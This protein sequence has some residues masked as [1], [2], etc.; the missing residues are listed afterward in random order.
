MI[1]GIELGDSSK[2]M[3]YFN[4]RVDDISYQIASVASS[5]SPG[6]IDATMDWV[7]RGLQ[8]ISILVA[9]GSLWAGSRRQAA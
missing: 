4:D 3:T 5:V 8:V 1:G 7:E 9:L 6:D 2:M